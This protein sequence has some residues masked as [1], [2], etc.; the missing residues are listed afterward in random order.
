MA[1]YG[2]LPTGVVASVVGESNMCSHEEKT[3]THAVE[4]AER[5][6]DEVVRPDVRWRKVEHLAGALARLA[7]Q[8]ALLEGTPNE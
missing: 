2:R 4:L 3:I 8:A 1:G 6:L 5:V 7:G